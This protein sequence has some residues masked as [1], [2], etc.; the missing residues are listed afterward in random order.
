MPHG[1]IIMPHIPSTKVFIS[2]PLKKKRG[3]KGP[4]KRAYLSENGGLGKKSS[5]DWTKSRKGSDRKSE[6][7]RQ[8]NKR[9]YID[10]WEQTDSPEIPDRGEGDIRN[11]RPPFRAKH[12]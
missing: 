4:H 11:P 12:W 8:K 7:T 5:G 9:G 2:Q 10:K 3:K 1:S 6:R